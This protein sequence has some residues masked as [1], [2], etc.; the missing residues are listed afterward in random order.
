MPR[1]KIRVMVVDDSAFMRKAIVR[2]LKSD[3]ML[4]VVGEARDGHEAVD[5]A[6]T[7][8]P[9]VITLDVKMPGMDGIQT[10]AQIMSK[11]PTPVLMVSSLTNE[12]GATTLKALE[13]GAVDFIDK[14]SCHT[15]LDI[16]DIADSLVNKVKVIAGVNLKNVEKP[17]ETPPPPPRPVREKASYVEELPEHLIVLGAS[18]GGPMALEKVLTDIEAGFR[19]AVLIV[20]HMPH[21]FTKSLADR[22]N[23]L[24]KVMVKEAEEDDLITRGGVF[25]APGG[26]HLKLRRAVD[27]YKIVLSKTPM[28][29]QHR[30]SVDV[31]FKSAADTWRGKLMGIVMTGMGSDGTEGVIALKNKGATI[32][33]QNES[34]CVVYGMPKS[35]KATGMVDRMVHL[36]S[37]SAEIN[38]F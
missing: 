37:I 20:Q 36:N 29:T 38:K 14:S 4:R 9:D 23:N 17:K 1:G 25:I 18:T 27:R 15:T 24:S 19:G 16:L 22:L 6:M 3:P 33:G 26:Y 8:K 35:A 5:K 10:L 31:L 2:M 21:G 34:T 28:D 7:L 30:P 13:M 32:I 11:Q 12:G